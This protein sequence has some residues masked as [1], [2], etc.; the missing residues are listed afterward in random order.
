MKTT[1]LLD[2]MD[3]IVYTIGSSKETGFESPNLFLF[4]RQ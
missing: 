2:R 4:S 3:K 1:F